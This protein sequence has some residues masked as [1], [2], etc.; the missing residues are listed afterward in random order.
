M[1][2]KTEDANLF[3]LSLETASSI[4]ALFQQMPIPLAVMTGPQH[5]IAFLNRPYLDLLHRDSDRDIIGR[6]VRE[7]LPELEGQVFFGLLDEVFESGIPSIGT[8]VLASLQDAPTGQTRE[9][10]FNFVYQPLRAEDNSIKGVLVQ[11]ADVTSFVNARQES[12]ER[13]G[14]V[15][16]QWSELEAIYHSAQVGLALISADDFRF[17][18]VNEEECQIVGA[19]AEN[20]LGKTVREVAPAIAAVVEKMLHQVVAGKVVR[21][22]PLIASLPERQGD[23]LQLR[24]SYHPVYS[25]DRRVS[26]ISCVTLDVSNQIRAEAA[27]I[28]SEKLA[29]V[30]RTASAI[31]LE[32]NNP[33]ASI[34]NLVHL[35]RGGQ[36]DA[37]TRSYLELADRELSRVSI[38][39]NQFVHFFTQ[40]SQ[41]R[42][43]T[44]N[45]LFISV[46][47]LYD[48]M[49][50]NLAIRVER[51]QCA[52]HHICCRDGDIRQAL[53]AIAANAIEAMPKGGRLLLRCQERRD[54]RV[55]R[56]GTVLTI[57]DTGTGI[58]PMIRS[59]LFDA[60]FTTKRLGGSGLGLWIV[61]EIM[62]RHNGWVRL[63]SSQ[64]PRSHGTVVSIFMPLT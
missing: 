44:C 55:D 11:A 34:T 30:A 22:V 57:A 21:D 41:S 20:I 53:Y 31:A 1:E 64:H 43:V 50:R 4:F 62:K 56:R 23:L 36:V 59:Q 63:R 40:T 3:G 47:T 10:Y 25:G 18:R 51:R 16:R 5:R 61:A 9:A 14:S 52:N 45:D 42:T 35:A 33:L 2:E 24:V 12:A 60:F 32:I 37:D 17:L 6:T 8:E 54:W 28:Q 26:A 19:P 13:E 29:A 38:V 15:H 58:D 7:V 48:L 39:T 46:L 27:L 49:L